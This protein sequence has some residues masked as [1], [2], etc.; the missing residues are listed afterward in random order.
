MIEAPLYDR[1]CAFMAA[2]MTRTLS[3]KL[4]TLMMTA[5]GRC[6]G[7]RRALTWWKRSSLT[8]PLAQGTLKLTC[9]SSSSQVLKKGSPMMQMLR[10]HHLFSSSSILS[11]TVSS[12]FLT[13]ASLAFF[14]SYTLLIIY[15]IFHMHTHTA[16]WATGTAT[17][18]MLA[19]GHFIEV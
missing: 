8:A 11:S 1:A 9:S 14:I 12:F 13:L 18:R 19:Q 15:Q 2:C 5:R 3:W 7:G 16:R 4:L 10:R 17:G 6:P